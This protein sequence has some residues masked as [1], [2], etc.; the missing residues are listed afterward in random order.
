MKIF[1]THN[2]QSRQAN[3]KHQVAKLFL[4]RSTGA[5]CINNWVLKETNT[6][7]FSLWKMMM[8]NL[9]FAKQMIKRSEFSCIGTSM[10]KEQEYS[11]IRCWYTS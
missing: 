8:A 5:I 9:E 2:T 11:T 10:I 7:L 6:L 3:L 1:G 4:D